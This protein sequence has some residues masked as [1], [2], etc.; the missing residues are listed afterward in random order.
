MATPFVWSASNRSLCPRVAAFLRDQTED[1]MRRPPVAAGADDYKTKP[2]SMPELMARIRAALRRVTV[3]SEGGTQI[4]TLEDV[5]I[6]PAYRR[7]SVGKGEVRITPKEFDLLHYVVAHPNI[8][9][10]HARL[11]QAVWGPDYGDEIEFPRTSI[12]QPRKKIEKDPS[13]PGYLLTEPWVGCR[14][15][16]FHSQQ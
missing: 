8:P 15:S 10:P 14:F 5:E 13:K 7:V 4:I 3:S 2:F 11:L 1:R 12:N 9:I 6:N 16:F